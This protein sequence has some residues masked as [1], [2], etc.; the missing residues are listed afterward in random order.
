LNPN[1]SRPA[2]AIESKMLGF[3]L[4]HEQFTVPQLIEI[5]VSAE[6]AGFDASGDQR[7]LSARA[8]CNCAL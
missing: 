8:R 3:M 4:A 1:S 2:R 5:G 7:P 6:Q